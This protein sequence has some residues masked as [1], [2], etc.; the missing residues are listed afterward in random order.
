MNNRKD[1]L[2]KLRILL[3]VGFN[4]QI[5]NDTSDHELLEFVEE[6]LKGKTEYYLDPKTI[7]IDAITTLYKSMENNND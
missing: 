7:D 1:N 6:L 3:A 4:Y 5:L 2:K